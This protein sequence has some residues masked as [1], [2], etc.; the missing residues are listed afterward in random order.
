MRELRWDI[1]KITDEVITAGTFHY[2]Q[3]TA[4]MEELMSREWG[5]HA[6]ATTS[7]TQALM[8]A[9]QASGI[10]AGDEVVVPAATFTATAFAVSA[11]GALPV[12]TDV[13][14]PTLT[15]DPNALEKAIT[16]RTRAVIPVHLHGHMADMPTINTIAKAHNL[17]VIEDCAQAAGASLRGRAAGT[18][19]D[20]GCFSFWV[21][22]T[23]GGLEDAGALITTTPERAEHL[24]RLTNMGRDS[25]NRNLHHVAGTRARLGELNAGVIAHELSLLPR[26]LRR[27]QQIADHYEREFTGLPLTTPVTEPEHVHARYKYAIACPDIAALATYLKEH[28]I[29]TEQVYPYL[30]PGQPAFADIKHRSNVTPQS[31]PAQHR[32][33]LPAYPELTDDEVRHIAHTVRSFYS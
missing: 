2:G 33:C 1:L 13:H 20:Y 27:R 30:L 23:I 11:L 21:G 32:L 19:G 7:C 16:D 8:L 10:Q 6:V 25:S 4:R 12:I 26:W 24:R 17:V 3:Q 31:H 28:S 14:E 5:G 22:K 18:W 29:Q 15:L 9:L